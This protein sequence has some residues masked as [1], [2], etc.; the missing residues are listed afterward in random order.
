MQGAA[1]LGRSQRSSDL[2]CLGGQ[3]QTTD[4]NGTS[5][6]PPSRSQMTDKTEW[7]DW[8]CLD[9][10]GVEKW[11]RRMAAQLPLAEHRRVGPVEQLL[12]NL[13]RRLAALGA[14]GWGE[15]TEPPDQHRPA[16]ARA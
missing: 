5:W 8:A 10:T 7:L 6:G 3:S 9:W 15:T 16:L 11:N 12:R 13:L 2:L 4:C 1:W 14:T